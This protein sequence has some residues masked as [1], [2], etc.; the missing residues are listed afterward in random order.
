MYSKNIY[1]NAC[2]DEDI[3]ADHSICHSLEDLFQI[4]IKICTLLFLGTMLIFQILFNVMIFITLKGKYLVNFLLQVI[5]FLV[6]LFM[7][8]FS[9]E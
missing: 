4:V 6:V 8:I 7:T 3:D 9:K 1:R 5:C 2:I